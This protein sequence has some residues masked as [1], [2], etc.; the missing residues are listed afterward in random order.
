VWSRSQNESRGIK[1]KSSHGA[2]SG[3]TCRAGSR[4]TCR[5]LSS[6]EAGWAQG[7][8]RLYICPTPKKYPTDMPGSCSGIVERH[9]D[10][11]AKTSLDRLSPPPLCSSWPRLAL[12]PVCSSPN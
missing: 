6:A 2:G 8:C 4:A 1:I 3:A 11:P 12:L 7:W 10:P 5:L 9:L